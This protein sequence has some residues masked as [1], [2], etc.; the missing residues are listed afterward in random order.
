MCNK[1]RNL[2]NAPRPCGAEEKK[3]EKIIDKI[4]KSIYYAQKGK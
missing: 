3:I 1:T 4:I 2:W